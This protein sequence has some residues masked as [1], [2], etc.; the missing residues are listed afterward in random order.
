MLTQRHV[1]CSVEKI[2]EALPHLQELQ[3]GIEIVFDSTNEL[4]PQ[5]RWE[6][7]LQQ[8]DAIHKAELTATIHGPFHGIN[9][10]SRDAHIR[11]FSETVLC[12]AIEACRSFESPLVVVHT[13]FTPQLAPKSRAKWLKNFLPA[14]TRVLKTAREHQVFL[15]IENTYEEDTELFHVIFNEIAHPHLRMCFD[16]GHAVCFGKVPPCQWLEEF[17]DR[18]CHVHLSDNDGKNDLHW[19]LGEGVIEFRKLLRPLVESQQQVSV[20][21]EVAGPDVPASEQYLMKLLDDIT[22]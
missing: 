10:G 7:L 3:L 9:L 16:T 19:S 17:G 14:L 12:G 18:I 6:N 20:T 15:A 8:A 4:W 22:N 1:Y 11:Q 21:Y 5:I 13:G 2:D